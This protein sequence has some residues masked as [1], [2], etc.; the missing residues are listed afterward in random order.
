[1]KKIELEERSR[2]K[3]ADYGVNDH[4]IVIGIYEHISKSREFP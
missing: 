4:Q 2:K 1:M 3:H